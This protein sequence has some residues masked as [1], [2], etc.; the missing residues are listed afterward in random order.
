MEV[1]V[2]V[3][4]KVGKGVTWLTQTLSKVT[5]MAWVAFPL[6]AKSPKTRVV[7]VPRVEL[8]S[9]EGNCIQLIPSGE[10]AGI[11]TPWVSWS[12]SQKGMPGQGPAG[13]EVRLP[14]PIRVAKSLW[15]P[16]LSW[17]QTRPPSEA[18]VPSFRMKRPSMELGPVVPVWLETRAT[19]WPLPTQFNKPA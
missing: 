6:Q 18:A 9:W 3:G 10:V 14:P 15:I 16:F 17:S 19:I 13:G 7:P 12:I 4:V 2:G 8:R 1:G 11:N 5:V